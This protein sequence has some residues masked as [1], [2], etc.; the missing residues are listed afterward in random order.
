ME[1]LVG[2]CLWLPFAYIG[3]GAGFALV[4]GV[5]VILLTMLA[6]AGTLARMPLR[7]ARGLWLRRGG[8]SGGP[9]RRVVIIGLDGMDPNLAQ[10]FMDEGRMP[11]FSRLRETGAYRKLRTTTPSMSPT[12]WSSFMTGVDASR[13][14]I[15]D[16]LTRDP[17]SYAPVLSSAEVRG[18]RYVWRVGPWRIPLGRPRVKLL[19]KGIPFWKRL[20]DK[21][22]FSTIIRVP[23]TFPPEKFHGCC[24]SGM[25]VPDL[26]GTQ[27]SFTHFTSEEPSE[28][29][30]PGGTVVLVQVEG[31]RIK[32][33]L[34]G[35]ENPI[36]EG[37]AGLESPLRIQLF[38]GAKEAE[39]RIGGRKVRLRQGVFSDWLPVPFRAA[40]GV[41]ARGIVRLYINSISPRFDMYASPVQI[42]PARPALPISHPFVYSVYLSKTVGT[43]GTLG[44]AEDT[45]ALNQGVIDEKA[46]LEQAYLY[47]EER[48]RML[49]D[50]L[51]KTRSGVCVC[52]F[53]GTDRIQ[54]MFFR[55]L[56]DDHPA[57]RGK[58]V[59]EHR[60]VLGDLYARMD[61]MIG[62]VLE[63][64]GP[65]T[66]LMVI[67]DHGF[68][69]FKRGVNLN[70]W[71]HQS[72]YLHRVGEAEGDEK[73]P[74]DGKQSG[75]GEQSGEGEQSG[76]GEW[77]E[78]VDWDRTRAYRLGLT[79]I[80]LN[81]KGREKRGIVDSA[82]L[83]ALKEE[84]RAG[85]KGLVD[86]E[87]GEKAVRE[88]YD[89][90]ALME[91][92]YAGDAPDLLVGF[93]AGYRVSWAGA[94]GKLSKDVIEDNTKAWSGDHCVDPSIVP[95]VFFCNEPVEAED[96]SILDIAPTVLK[97]FGMPVPAQLQGTDL[98]VGGHVPA[99]P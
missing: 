40:P 20:G 74:R 26:R 31:D 42:D 54:H 4:G 55:T 62:K 78:G 73:P 84:I 24:L 43:Y 12:A 50:A 21:G 91:G 99:T 3:P 53:D 39:V 6:A 90:T 60:G 88:V 92:P 65:D 51:E 79:G 69:Q 44:L 2:P 10:R 68:T 17:F 52:V 37:A 14:G 41:S 1:T 75:D 35:P 13:H 71:L 66:L 47:H 18:P 56:D 57:N 85:L 97:L 29:A 5:F 34:P 80:F 15:F 81:R 7:I 23:I 87:S 38:P 89:T 70:T 76:D 59:E 33:A 95:G 61:G 63:T 9:Y 11:N 77:L 67:S 28:G 98:G 16:F 82:A 93:N 27:G 22:V 46:F 25:C 32:T 48:E 8:A 94:T 19:R 36:R 72:G 58:E 96:P 83:A 49:F 30:G 45:W 64:I 86:P